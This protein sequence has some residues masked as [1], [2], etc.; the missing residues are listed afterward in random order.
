MAPLRLAKEKAA[1][2]SQ[3]RKQ[4]QESAYRWATATLL[5]PHTSRLA[6][7]CICMK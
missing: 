2:E 7:C 3:E 1:K 5:W 4:A 6:A